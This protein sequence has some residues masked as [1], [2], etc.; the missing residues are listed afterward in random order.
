MSQLVEIKKKTEICR[1]WETTSF[2]FGHLYHFYVVIDTDRQT[3]TNTHT[4]RYRLKC[5]LCCHHERLHH[6]VRLET[7]SAHIQLCM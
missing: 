4:H 1:D 2:A 7:R 3:D 5:L 6:I